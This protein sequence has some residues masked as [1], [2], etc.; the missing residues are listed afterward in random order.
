MKILKFAACVILALCAKVANSQVEPPIIW[1]PIRG[2]NIPGKSFFFD[3]GSFDSDE[4]HPGKIFTS[5]FILIQSISPIQVTKDNKKITA[6]SMT[7]FII[8]EC[9]SG[10]TGTLYDLYF[11]V[12]T[13]T[14]DTKPIVIYE[15]GTPNSSMMILKSHL[16]STHLCVQPQSKTSIS[17]LNLRFGF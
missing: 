3:K 17:N 9:K 11:N 4:S 15:Y 6:L 10:L 12:N 14:L 16:L 5:G 8:V 13:P 1:E 7:K 2:M